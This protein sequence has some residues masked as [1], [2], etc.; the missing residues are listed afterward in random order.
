MPSPDALRLEVRRFR[1][2][3]NWDWALTDAA[4]QHLAAHSVR[5]DPASPHYQAMG[6]LPVHVRW[7]AD[8][9]RLLE[10]EAEVLGQVGRWLGE[11]VFGAVGRAL[12]EHSPVTALV[13]VGPDAAALRYWPL[14][15][16]W[17]GQ[18]PLA[19]QDVSLV[20][21]VDQGETTLAKK[22]VGESLRLLAVFSLSAGEPLLM[23][24]QQRYELVRSIQRVAAGKA[25]SI[26]LVTLQH[27]VTRRRLADILEEGE[28]WDVI[29][30]SGHGLASGLL[31]EG[32]DGETDLVSTDELIRLLRPARKRLK[33]LV[34]SACE[35]AG[36]TAGPRQPA[37]TPERV[38]VLSV[39]AARQLDC[40]VLGMRY[41]VGDDFSI[42]LAQHLYDSLLAKGNLLPR[43]LQLALPKALEHWPEPGN[44]A[45]S[46][47]APA[48]FGARAVDLSLRPPPVKEATFRPRGKPSYF[49]REPDLFAGRMETMAAATKALV[50][51]DGFSGIL[52][53]GPEATGKTACAV[54]L[55][56]LF[57]DRFDGL[58]R[59][60]AP[61]YGASITGSSSG[62]PRRWRPSCRNLARK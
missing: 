45:L 53:Q 32:T 47:A 40:A 27:G 28:G 56:Y 44:P 12:V 26:D 30:F 15:L 36:V 14:E 10:S 37:E 23:L 25:G 54:E 6:R 58:V 17:V 46:V 52:F 8:A 34:L 60:D 50:V 1:D 2:P 39:E 57:Q 20:I 3:E 7:K 21:D 61:G 48:L 13:V 31:L 38:P 19:C 24:S 22:Q 5:I 42:Q 4:G 55:A 16:A 51:E 29:H 9:E 49:G 59:H 11:E 18:Q 35:S 33:L 62:W 43:A 41:A